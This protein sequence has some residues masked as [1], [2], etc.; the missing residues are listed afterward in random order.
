MSS[1]NELL[2]FSLLS[3]ILF[4]NQYVP[5]IIMS[6][7]LLL[8]EPERSVVSYNYASYEKDDVI[9]CIAAAEMVMM[10]KIKFDVRFFRH[11]S[12]VDST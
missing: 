2:H 8:A 9:S 3:G 4:T 7:Y 10:L 1:N 11:T 6:I 5:K 12:M